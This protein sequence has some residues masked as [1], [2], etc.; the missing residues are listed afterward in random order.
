MDNSRNNLPPTPS[1]ISICHFMKAFLQLLL[2]LLLL[3]PG[4]LFNKI[5]LL[6]EQ[7]K[8]QILA[9]DLM[10]SW[11]IIRKYLTLA[12]KKHLTTKLTKPLTNFQN[13][14]CFGNLPT[15][16]CCFYYENN[17]QLQL[18]NKIS[19]IIKYFLKTVI[20]LKQSIARGS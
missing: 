2:L 16:T 11:R 7:K 18:A 12:Q 15:S 8:V 1:P 14:C 19:N 17:V 20:N 9:V 13:I 5:S 6:K 4:F 3:L 10:N